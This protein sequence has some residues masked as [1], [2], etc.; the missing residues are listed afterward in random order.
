MKKPGLFLIVAILSLSLAACG[1][2]SSAKTTID[3]MMTDF[4][5]TP[6]TF[7]I[8]AGEVI[9]FTAKNDGA[10]V[11]NFVIMNSDTEVGDS[12]GDEDEGNVYWKIEVGAGGEETATFTAPIDPGEY[13]LVCS[14]PGHY[15]AGMI[16]KII[17]V[18]P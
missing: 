11:H 18:A 10:V 16:G 12:F 3:V 17:V 2:G 4:T 8:P 9:T 7:T 14:T 15:M 5:Y 1:G 6:N 13:Q